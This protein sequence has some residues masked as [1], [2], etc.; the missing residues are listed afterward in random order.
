M[1]TA[2]LGKQE[3]MQSAQNS[4]NQLIK[5]M[6]LTDRQKIALTCRILFEDGHDAGLSGQITC[7]S[8][9][10]GTF[11]TQRFGLGFDEI[12]ADNLLEVDQ[13]LK[14]TNGQG[15][16]NPANR[17]H[18]WIYKE[19]PDVNCIIHTHPTHIA[20]LSML[21]VPLMVA[22]MDTCCLYQDCSFVGDWPGVPVGNEE[23]I[24]ISGALGQKRAILLAHHGQLVVGKTIEEACNL[25]ILIERAAK[26]QLLAMAAGQVQPLPDTLA[27]EAHDWVS[28]DK[29]NK[30]NFAYYAR[31]ALKIHPDCI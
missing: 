8:D 5:D 28:T 30:V 15:M 18:T 17:F 2:S 9:A 26:L 12:T 25:A 1:R 19:H 10:P 11:I 31:R 20:A 4:M 24:I 6:D 22:Q 29:R 23:G 27:R 3:L 16:A 13:D 7:R 21:R 14:P